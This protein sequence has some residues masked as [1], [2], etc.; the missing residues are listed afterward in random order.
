MLFCFCIRSLKCNLNL[1]HSKSVQHMIKQM[2]KISNS[3][4]VPRMLP[5]CRL[6]SQAN[7][8]LATFAAAT[9]SFY[10]HHPVPS[11]SRVVACFKSL[12]QMQF[13]FTLLN[14]ISNSIANFTRWLVALLFLSIFFFCCCFTHIVGKRG[15]CYG[16]RFPLPG[17]LVKG[18]Y[19]VS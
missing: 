11:A 5:H 19:R 9:H 3:R 17:S 2:M 10:Q 18:T 12:I 6:V 1:N 13:N 4:F 7:Q 15:T 14:S 8:L 16:K